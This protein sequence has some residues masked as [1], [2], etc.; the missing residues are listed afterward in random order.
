MSNQ[1]NERPRKNLAVQ[2]LLN[3]L[4][5]FQIL[6]RLIPFIALIGLIVFFTLLAGDRFLTKTNLLIVL[7]QSCVVAIAG[8]GL[9]FIIVSGS[10]DLSSGSVLALTGMV[11]ADIAIKYGWGL[12]VVA[13]IVVGALCGA[14]NGFGFSILKIPSFIVTLG[15]LSMARGATIMYSHSRPVMLLDSYE[16]LGS[17]PTIFLGGQI[18][19]TSI[20]AM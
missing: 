9:T 3:T 18:F 5:S 10:I 1:N 17:N 8:F 15:M 6:H 19:P 12:G 11:A 2:P 16:F 7:Q 4:P 20:P 13:G 14:I